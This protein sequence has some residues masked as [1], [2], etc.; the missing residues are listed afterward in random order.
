MS[1]YIA[2]QSVVGLP[3]CRVLGMGSRAALNGLHCD[4]AG[5]IL[6]VEGALPSLGLEPEDIM[7]DLALI[8]VQIPR[9]VDVYVSNGAFA[10]IGICNVLDGELGVDSSAAGVG[11]TARTVRTFRGD[12]AG[13]AL[14]N[15]ANILGDCKLTLTG[16]GS[17]AV[18]AITGTLD[19][20]TRAPEPSRWSRSDDHESMS[21]PLWRQMAKFM[22][23]RGRSQHAVVNAACPSLLEHFGIVDS[24]NLTV[25]ATQAHVTFATVRILAHRIEA[26]TA[27]V[28]GRLLPQSLGA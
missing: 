12:I 15:V 7:R 28:N 2:V 17:M 4:L 14:I 20:Q 10:A 5:D 8:V 3:H 25:R 13:G 16:G 11:V 23:L 26:G 6:K 21:D 24:A 9:R 19:V 27:S 1:A 22:V 18:N